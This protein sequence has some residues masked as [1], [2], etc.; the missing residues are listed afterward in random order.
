MPEGG[1]WFDIKPDHQP[2]GSSR[3][4][5]NHLELTI[6]KPDDSRMVIKCKEI[7]VHIERRLQ[8]TILRGGEGDDMEDQGSESALYS[9]SAKATLEQYLELI[10][11][12]RGDQPRILEP[13]EG[14]EIKVAF[15]NISYNASKGELKTEIIQ[16]I[17]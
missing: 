2:H 1:D 3:E 17:A 14:G 12:F 15:S 6:V 5:S 13:F 7:Q 4:K 10:E 11:V 16:D 8:R 9:I